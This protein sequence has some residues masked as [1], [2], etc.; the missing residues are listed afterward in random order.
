MNVV[1]A[2]VVIAYLDDLDVHH[3]EAIRVI[4]EAGAG[5][6]MHPITIAEVLV[7]P[8]RVGRAA[9]VWT[10]LAAIGMSTDQHPFDFLQ[11][12]E[13]RATTRLKMPDCC[14]LASSVNHEAELLTFN[15]RLRLA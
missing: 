7:R 4:A 2:G 12:A 14:V 13:L 15:D 6:M 3:A 8:A 9:D 10:E 11:L 1:D 5:L